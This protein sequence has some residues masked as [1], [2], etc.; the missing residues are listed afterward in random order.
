MGP[1]YVIR[2][3]LKKSLFPVKRVAEI[4]AS[5]AAA[6][7]FFFPLFFS[8]VRISV[9]GKMKKKVPILQLYIHPAAGQET[10]FFLRVAS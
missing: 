4:V 1:V 8:M 10:I 9:G 5:Q 2:P 6:K 7:S 3:P